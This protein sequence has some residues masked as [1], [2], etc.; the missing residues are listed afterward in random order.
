[1][2]SRQEMETVI[3]NGGS[4]MLPNG[5]VIVRVE[6]IPPDENLAKTSADLD[7][8]GKD[9]DAQIAALQA[10]RQQVDLQVARSKRD[11]EAAAQAAKKAAEDAPADE[12][13]APNE[14]ESLADQLPKD[15]PAP[16]DSAAK[17]KK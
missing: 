16:E 7:A 12:P 1:M 15:I 10:R 9:L 8:V 4:V 14:V 6:D 2:L 17:K 5:A 11:A 3:K 13:P